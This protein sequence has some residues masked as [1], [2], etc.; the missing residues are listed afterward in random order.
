MREDVG[1]SGQSTEIQ[2]I[3]TKKMQ[4]NSWRRKDGNSVCILKHLENTF[5]KVWFPRIKTSWACF[6][7]EWWMVKSLAASFYIQTWMCSLVRDCIIPCPVIDWH[8]VQRV[9]H[10]IFR[11]MCAAT[12]NEMSSPENGWM[13]IIFLNLVWMPKTKNNY[14]LRK[15]MAL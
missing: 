6:I 11:L 9:A 4:K 3:F 15:C 8:P 14:R 10:P 12:L 2:L 5:I 1:A 13:D 7:V